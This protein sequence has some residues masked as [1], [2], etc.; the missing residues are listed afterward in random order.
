[1]GTC[2]AGRRW[3]GGSSVKQV[4]LDAGALIAL[5]RRD[6]RMVALADEL[7]KAR[8]G[9]HVPAGVVGQAWR[10][11]ARQA[12]IARLLRSRGVAVDPLTEETGYL[13]GTLLAATGSSDVIDAHVV[14]LARRVHGTVV[15]SDPDDIS[16]LDPTLTIARV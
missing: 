15:T 16:A 3:G 1:M 12:P 7:V 8:Q 10:G 4:V 14:L 9:A 11:S 5:E 13:T 2:A 6:P